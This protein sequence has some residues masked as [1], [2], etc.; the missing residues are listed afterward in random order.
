MVRFGF[1][2]KKTFLG[3]TEDVLGEAHYVKWANT[4]KTE[5]QPEFKNNNYLFIYLFIFK[6]QLFFILL[7]NFFF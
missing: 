1:K 6:I 7:K 2:K 5:A 4:K 3:R